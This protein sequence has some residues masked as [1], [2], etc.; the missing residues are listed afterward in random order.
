M[1]KY[2]IGVLSDTH[3]LL[4]EEVLEILQGCDRILHGGD[5]NR[6]DI[7]DRLGEIAPVYAVRGNNDKE[8]AEYL[9]ETLRVEVQGIKIF[10]VHNKKQIP[11]DLRGADLVIYGHS[12]K[13]EE[14]WEGQRLMLNPGSC[15][16]RRFSQ[17]V[18][19]AVIE[20][21]KDGSMHVKKY[22]IPNDKNPKV[23]A[24]EDSEKIP[25]NIKL[26]IERT[27]RDISKGKTVDE[28]AER[29]KISKELAE[30]ICRLYLTHPGVDAE[31]I[32]RKMGL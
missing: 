1:K 8:W 10:M 16:P 32:M 11:A 6:K 7:L 2:K 31:G 20:I 28:I 24:A 26:I 9:P 3:G 19:M 5:I 4:R 21:E 13:Y 22:Q 29:N 18:T 23:K 30:Q 25:E 14:K 17:P 27:I 12:H 15:G